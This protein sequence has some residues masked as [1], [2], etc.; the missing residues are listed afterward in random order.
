MEDRAI[1][2]M[3]VRMLRLLDDLAAQRGYLQKRSRRAVDLPCEDMT[4]GM[5]SSDR[6]IIRRNGQRSDAAALGRFRPLS[7]DDLERLMV[8]KAKY[9]TFRSADRDQ[10]RDRKT[11]RSAKVALPY[12]GENLPADLAQLGPSHNRPWSLR[13]FVR[14]SIS[15]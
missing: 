2:N 15:L 11:G 8:V 9:Q 1:G 12:L 14:G 6:R 5:A 3:P 7:N 13:W 4:I 10:S